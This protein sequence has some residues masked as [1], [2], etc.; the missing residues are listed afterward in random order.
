MI[1]SY[2]TAASRNFRKNKVH[3]VINVVGLGLGMMASILAIMFVMDENSFDQFHSRKD[4]L[5]RLNKI[6]VEEDGSSYMNAE[7]SGMIG[8]TMVNEFPEVS[9]VVR[10]HPWYGETLLSRDEKNMVTNL[11]DLAF[12]DST[13]FQ[14]FDFKLISGNPNTVLTR[15]STIVLTEKI[16]RSLFGQQDPIGKTI[17]GVG[18]LPFEVTGIAEEPPRNSHIQFTGLMSWTTT[19][20]NLGPEKLQFE[21]MNNWIAQGIRT[22]VLLNEG[23]NVKELE[24]KF[25]AFMQNH[26]PTRVN[27]YK[28][29]LQPFTDLYLNSSDVKYGNMAKVGSKEFLNLFSIIAGFILFI[30]CI[31]YINISTSKSTRR[32]REVGM[33]KTMGAKKGQLVTQFLGESFLITFL[34]AILALVLVYLMVPYF[35]NLAGKS[36]PL[37]LLIDRT[38]IFGTG[39]LIV[40]VSLISGIYPSFIIS[41]FSPAEVLRAS[42]KSRITGNW[43]RY[44]LITFQ[45]AVSIVMISG[46]LLV[47]EQ[48]QFVLSK[49]LGFDKENIMVLNL[50]E[51]I[52]RKKEVFQ[53]EIDMLPGVVSTSVG[54]TALGQG[55]YS[56]YVIPEGFNPDEVEVRTFPADCNF[57]KTYGLEMAEGRFFDPASTTD[58]TAFIINEAMARRLNWGNPLTKTIKFD[59]GDPAQPVIGVLKDFNFNSLY[60][61]VEPLVMW[62]SKERPSNMS[63]RFSGNPAPLIEALESKWKSYESRNPF[64]YYFL[65]QA[66][67]KSYESEDKLLKTIMTFAGLSIIIACL[68]L[69]GLVSYTIEQRTKEFG[70]RKVLGA[71]VASLN[72]LVNSKFIAMV[73]ISSVI[74]IPVVI[75]LIEK[76]LEKFA[77]KTQLGPGVFV[78]AV[79]ITLAVTIIAVSAHAIKVARA[80]PAES[81]RHE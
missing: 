21:W 18:G 12:A 65:D 50:T 22:Y 40:L 56:T 41:S 10:F 70:I 29:Y 15:P 60:Q 30:A 5:F 14:V 16:A 24:G 45:F 73:L 51:E 35:N 4:Q 31:N 28:P 17:L 1:G 77:F 34:S 8:P 3:T 59:V 54:R 19:V 76:W 7:S 37:S 38:V 6:F 13:F 9:K 58:S 67:A 66:Y 36:L 52:V 78:I 80:N 57:L 81:L 26:M 75:P 47:Y 27:K 61:E 44:I 68:G 2:L 48:I 53:Q 11:A 32:S 62:I 46:T 43:P 79:L 55:S 71:S 39:A 64:N 49:D 42:G 23:A 74:G 33:R 25:P 20:P 72:F 69:Y 63:L